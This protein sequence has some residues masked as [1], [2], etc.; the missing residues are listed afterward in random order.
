MLGAIGVFLKT[1]THLKGYNFIWKA[2]PWRC[3]SKAAKGKFYK[4]LLCSL[5][6]ENGKLEGQR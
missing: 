1:E 4:H 5:S 2:Q 6:P 3:G